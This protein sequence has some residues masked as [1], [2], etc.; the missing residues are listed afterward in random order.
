MDAVG[1]GMVVWVFVGGLPAGGAIAAVA[2]WLIFRHERGSTAARLGFI[3]EAQVRLRDTFQ[4]LS[5]EALRLNNQSF[6]DLAKTSLGEFQKGASADLES[7][8]KAIDALL[9]P[10]G[11]SLGKM[12]AKLGDIEKERHGHYSSLA[13]QLQSVGTAQEK[14]QLETANLVK[15]LR[16]PAVRGRWGE[17]QLRRVVEIAGMMEHCDFDEQ[18]TLTSDSGRL[19]PD[20]IVRLPAGKNLVVD[21]KAPLGAYL[22]ALEAPEDAERERLMRE[23]ARQVRDHMAKLASKAYFEQCEPSPEFVV[24]FLPGESFFSAAL[25]Y[26]PGLIE[27]GVGERVIPASPTTLIALLRAVAYGWRQETIAENAQHISALGRELHDRIAT[28]ARH[29]AGVGKGL[30][31]AIGAYNKAVGSLESRVLVSARR[32]KE[33]GVAAAED[34][35]TLAPV[36]TA[37]RAP[38][39]IDLTDRSDVPARRGERQQRLDLL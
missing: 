27:Y 12:D 26:D 15:A 7:R 31:Q 13:T 33:L 17:I 11:D 10:I 37:G 14:L 30:E 3:D 4:A 28:L 22:D 35:D 29:F 36:E 2:A 19:R 20:M 32:F 25:Q 8:Q 5:A 21:A 39:A 23:H 16:A 18:E 1:A 24:M 9:K 6:L 34:I 38:Q